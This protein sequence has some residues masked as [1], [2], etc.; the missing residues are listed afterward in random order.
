M[1]VICAP[2]SFKESLTAIEAANAIAAGVRRAA[3]GAII[4]KCPVGDGGEGTLESLLESIEGE[5]VTAISSNVF[6]QP[7]EANFGL[8]ENGRTVF[9]ESAAAIGL[10][11]IPAGERDVMHS[12]SFGVGQLIMAALTHSPRKIIVGIGGSASNDC[13]CGMAQALG[14][15]FLDAAGKLISEPIS[16]SMLEDIQG[17]DAAHR[18]IGICEPAIVVASDVNNPLTGLMGAAR[19]FAPQKGASEQQV[20][21]LDD[22]LRH[23]AELIRRDMGIDIEAIAGAGAAGGLGAGLMAFAGAEIAS[24]IDIVLT[25]V[26]FDE[27]VQNADL[28]LTGEGCLD[29]QSLS[30][31]ACSGVA[32]ASFARGVPAIALVGSTG[33]GVERTLNAGLSGYLAIGEGLTKEESIRQASSLLA[34]AAHKV[35]SEFL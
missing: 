1:K 21:M 20:A 27:R 12:S 35:T 32:K 7:V 6:G 18:A 30:G 31:K 24:G 11:T 10:A 5:L 15:R 34:T 33:P 22:G 28:C 26:R 3:P 29:A 2:D 19:I 9:I 4:D 17:I 23:V 13:G 16:G 14:I 25:A 8:L